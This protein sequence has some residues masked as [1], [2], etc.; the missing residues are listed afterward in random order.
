LSAH[1][2]ARSA[3]VD[4]PRLTLVHSN[5]AELPRALAPWLQAHQVDG[6]LLDL[7]VSS[8]QLDNAERGFSFQHEGPLDMRMDV[9]QGETAAE[10][11]A[12]RS[13]AELSDLIFRFGEER[14]AKAVAR[15]LKEPPLPLTT[16]ELAERVSRAVRTR[17]PGKHPAT[18]TFQ[19][20]RIAVNDELGAL[21]HGGR[22]VVISFHS[23]EDRV[24]KQFMRRASTPPPAD[25]RMPVVAPF[26]A[27]LVDVQKPVF[28]DAAELAHNPR[29]RSAV[30]RVATRAPF[31]GAAA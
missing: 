9:S 27:T 26:D 4:E 19:A 13:E 17:E 11:I 22:L 25:R 16:R 10:L 28:P 1:D 6:L 29:A 24:V 8:P 23:L 12:N 14:F 3:F 31:S 18:R 20:L 7:G 5:F 21:E 2:Y 15:A 30:L